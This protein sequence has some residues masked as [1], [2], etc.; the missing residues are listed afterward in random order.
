MSNDQNQEIKKVMTDNL[1]L[2]STS[3]H[4]SDI[5]SHA[6]QQKRRQHF[7]RLASVPAICM[8][9]I[10]FIIWTI[11]SPIY[12]LHDSHSMDSIAT[13][14]MP[15]ININYEKS[16]LEDKG[17]QIEASSLPN[18]AE[19]TPTST[20]DI[21]Y[22]STLED[23]VYNADAVIKGRILGTKSFIY[24]KN[25][26]AYTKAKVL[27]T[28][29]YNDSLQK[30]QIIT[31]IKRG[32]II[33]KYEY[34]MTMNMN[35][36]FNFTEKELQKAKSEKVIA[37]NYGELLQADDQAFFFLTRDNSIV[38][39]KE[40]DF[41]TYGPVV[42]YKDKE[43][44]REV[45]TTPIEDPFNLDTFYQKYQYQDLETQI[46][47][48]VEAKGDYSKESIRQMAFLSL[49]TS[50]Q[51][52]VQNKDNASVKYYA[53]GLVNLEIPKQTV[54]VTFATDNNSVIKVL[55]KPNEEKIL[56]SIF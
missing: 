11:Q 26:M 45:Q 10:S 33:T 3:V 41:N 13:K 54:V 8:L 42:K 25:Q 28:D 35:E 1:N 2:Q 38:P 53:N 15:T 48:Y 6:N 36:K 37:Y 44:I 56:K 29:T 51:H 40:Y 4:F 46:E 23:F 7:I 19:Q 49:N 18:T 17:Y 16:L 27:V 5:W 21:L 20:K 24:K 47:Q 12:T 22:Q 55:V 50:R 32:A 52:T 30:N 14:E 43:I 9:V 34:M 31:I 39:T